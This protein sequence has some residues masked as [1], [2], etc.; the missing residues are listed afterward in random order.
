MEL[1]TC[2][3]NTT[4]LQVFYSFK[5]TTSAKDCFFIEWRK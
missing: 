2:D 5:D 3:I 4:P 1:F